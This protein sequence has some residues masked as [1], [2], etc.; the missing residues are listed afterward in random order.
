MTEIMD[1]PSLRLLIGKENLVG[2]EIG[3]YKGR[4][5]KE[6]LE[7]L[8]IKKIY[9]IDNWSR[10]YGNKEKC[11]E[12]LKD[13]AEKIVWL[14]GRS[15]KMYENIEDGELGFVYVDGG[16]KE[17]QVDMDLNLYWPKLKKGGLMCGHDYQGG[18]TK[19]VNKAVDKFFKRKGLEVHSGEC[20]RSARHKD[21]WVWKK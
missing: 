11:A 7:N 19:G 21:W 20:A 17:H 3:V 10:K 5:A 1:R 16:H 2:A 6:I 9:L 18:K 12:V 13:H 14:H 15:E 8:D 4:N